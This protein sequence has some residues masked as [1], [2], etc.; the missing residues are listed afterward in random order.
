MIPTKSVISSAS[1][2]KAYP[3]FGMC[4]GYADQTP[5]VKPRLPLEAIFK[6]DRYEQDNEEGFLKAYDRVT[7]AYYQTRDSNLK[8]QTWTGQIADFMSLKVRPHMKS[9]LQKQGF[10]RQ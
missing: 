8:A 2:K 10:F 7:N 5:P 6:T 3:V 4:L 1:L 9:F